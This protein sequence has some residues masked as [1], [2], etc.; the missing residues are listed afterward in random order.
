MAVATHGETF[1]TP[2]ELPDTLVAPPAGPQRLRMPLSNSPFAHLDLSTLALTAPITTDA[3]FSAPSSF[4][5]RAPNNVST[6]ELRVN[7]VLWQQ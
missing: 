3:V 1:P 7:D 4:T 6:L 2:G 5:Q